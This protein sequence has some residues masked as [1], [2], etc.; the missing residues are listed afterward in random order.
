MYAHG[1]I[2]AALFQ[3]SKTGKGTKIDV[4]LFSTQVAC[5]INVGVN[6]LNANKEAKR[7]G[8]AHESIAPYSAF[9]TKNG[10]VT[11]GV[12]NE[13]Q[14]KSLCQLIGAPEL[15]EN[16]KFISN[17]ERVKNRKELVDIL[18]EIFKKETNEVWMAKFTKATFPFAPINNLQ[19]VFQ[20]EHVKAIGLVK[21]LEHKVAG[22]VKVVGPPVTYS[23]AMNSVQSAPPILGQHTYQVLKNILSYDDDKITLLRDQK[24]IQ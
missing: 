19:N 8:T 6:Y 13:S 5:L 20:D 22:N 11:V 23:D 3:R 4:D 17:K 2:L 15:I 12:G 7:W 14:Y 21:T 1:A 24:I 9:E 16:P 18:S 10:F